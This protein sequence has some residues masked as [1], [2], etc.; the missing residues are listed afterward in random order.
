M[1][2]DSVPGAGAE[3]TSTAAPA[4]KR[5]AFGRMFSFWRRSWLSVRVLAA[6]GAL[7]LPAVGLSIMLSTHAFAS[8][9]YCTTSP[10]RGGT[11]SGVTYNSYID[12]YADPACSGNRHVAYDFYDSASSIIP[13]R[14]DLARAWVCGSLRAT[15]QVPSS[16]T[17]NAQQLNIWS[18]WSELNTCGFQVDMSSYFGNPVYTWTYTNL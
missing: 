15:W 17:V 4:D 18:G 12:A 5:R 3:R 16:G 7:V 9:T 6:L 2:A 1:H 13:M 11:I 14:I 10:V 8:T